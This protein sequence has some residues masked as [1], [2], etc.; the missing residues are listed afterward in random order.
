MQHNTAQ[1]NTKQHNTTQHN[2]TQHNTTQHST[3]Q[4][5]TTQHNATQHNT[6]QHKTTQHNATQHNTA[7]HNKT[8]HSKIHY[9]ILPI[10]DFYLTV[11]RLKL[12]EHRWIFTPLLTMLR[13]SQGVYQC[14][15][16][17]PE[18]NN[19]LSMNFRVTT[20]TDCS[21]A[22]TYAAVV[23]IISLHR[24]WI[25]LHT[26]FDCKTNNWN[27][28]FIAVG[29]IHMAVIIVKKWVALDWRK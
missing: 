23:Q 11:I 5:K 19:C 29:L 3:A 8:K 6:A 25:I 27:L 26:E 18:A 2:A 17:E 21:F 28:C 1:H 16:T 20:K 12:G 14:S 22:H 10:G 7:Q 24:L 13:R 9:G 4:H 15:S